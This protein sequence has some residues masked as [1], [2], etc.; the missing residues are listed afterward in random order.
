MSRKH[1]VKLS[2]FEKLPA[3][4]NSIVPFNWGDIVTFGEGGL[5]EIITL[6]DNSLGEARTV[7]FQ[8]AESFKVSWP[9]TRAWKSLM[10]QA[11]VSCLS[12][13]VASFLSR[14]RAGLCIN[15]FHWDTGLQVFGEDSDLFFDY[16]RGNSSLKEQILVD[17]GGRQLLERFW[18]GDLNRWRVF[19]HRRFN[20]NHWEMVGPTFSKIKAIGVFDQMRGEA[21]KIRP[22]RVRRGVY[23]NE[24]EINTV[25]LYHGLDLVAE[26]S[27]L[28]GQGSL[29]ED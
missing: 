28:I 7:D 11:K 24:G 9:A 17:I 20:W 3:H 12:P 8:V 27:S 1:T 2:V 16:L 10:F 21:E 22:R 6:P 15:G 26:F 25:L 4:E 13:K 18:K 23:W 5:K 14:Y 19:I 29:K